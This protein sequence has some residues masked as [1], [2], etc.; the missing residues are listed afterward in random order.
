MNLFPCR[1]CGAQPQF[2]GLEPILMKPPPLPSESK[3]P[4]LLEQIRQWIL[5]DVFIR[6]L[7][8]GFIGGLIVLLLTCLAVVIFSAI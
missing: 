8:V 7:L 3:R 4:N 6:L 2:L 5:R 1:R